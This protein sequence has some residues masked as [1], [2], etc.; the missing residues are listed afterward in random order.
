ML[1]L[2]IYAATQMITK[3]S[4]TII[5]DMDGTLFDSI[6]ALHEVVSHLIQE[7]GCQPISKENFRGV[8][9]KGSKAMIQHSFKLAEND[10]RIATI[11]KNLLTNYL[12]IMADKTPFFPPALE[13]FSQLKEKNISWGIVTNRPEYLAQPLIEKYNLNKL[14]P[15][16]VFGDTLEKAKPHPE[17]LLHACKLLNADP[18]HSLYVGDTEND[19]IAAKAAGMQAI[20]AQYGYLRYDSKQQNLQY[21]FAINNLTELLRLI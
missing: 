2:T 11:Q 4:K 6:H 7:R 18:Q 5:F 15:C 19:M 9:D 1:A 17:P 21:N 16:L 13:L 20:F 8:V 12:A 14:T 3:P 10:P